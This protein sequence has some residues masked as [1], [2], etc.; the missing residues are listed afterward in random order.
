MRLSAQPS[1][2]RSIRRRPD[3][4]VRRLLLAERHPHATAPP[5]LV[6]LSLHRL[7]RPRRPVLQHRHPL[8]HRPHPHQRQLAPHA[9]PP[10]LSTTPSAMEASNAVSP[11]GLHKTSPAPRTPSPLPAT[12]PISPMSSI[13]SDQSPQP[14]TRIPLR[15]AKSLPPSPASL[16]PFGSGRILT[17]AP[18][19][20]ALSVSRLTG[21]RFI[22]SMH[23]IIR[24]ERSQIIHYS[25]PQLGRTLSGL[26]S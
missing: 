22:R 15:S 16:T 23:A 12:P 11:H 7:S 5:A 4:Q 8:R 1:R 6:N 19:A 21:N 3:F 17:N 14:Q 25:L 9:L 13:K 18:E 20:K 24:Q 10:I 2:P 26:S